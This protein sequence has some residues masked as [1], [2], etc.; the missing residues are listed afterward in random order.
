MSFT[1]AF[2][3]PR[4]TWALPS[5]LFTCNVTVTEYNSRRICAEAPWPVRMGNKGLHLTPTVLMHWSIL[6]SQ[7]LV[8]K[9]VNSMSTVSTVINTDEITLSCNL[10]SPYFVIDMVLE[11]INK[12]SLL[13]I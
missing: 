5:V 11:I 12:E 10:V 7:Q 6:H 1:Q 3:P 8:N 9:Q 2:V 13:S 4:N